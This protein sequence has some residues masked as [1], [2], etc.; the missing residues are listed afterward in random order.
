MEV[1]RYRQIFDHSMDGILLTSPDGAV[2]DANPAACCILR[3]SR[4]QICL[5][6]RAGITVEDDRLRAII[7][8]RGRRGRAC[9]EVLMVRIDGEVFPAEMS[10]SVY[11]DAFGEA[12]TSLIFRDI[13][14]RRRQEEE[15][16]R[17][18]ASLEDVVRERTARLHA[19]HD[20]LQD[21]AYALAHDLH[22]PL[23]A[24]GGL[25]GVIEQ[26]GPPP[27]AA[28]DL[29]RIRA[30]V[31]AMG[32]M[33]DSLQALALIGRSEVKGRWVD[34]AAIVYLCEAAHKAH[35]MRGVRIDA[36]AP[37]MVY[38]DPQLLALVVDE[39]LTNAAK[40]ARQGMPACVRLTADPHEPVA[41]VCGF[42]GFSIT[43]NGIG[44]PSGYE[45]SL[46]R[47]FQR[48]HPHSQFP[49]RGMGL[50]K[51][52]S[53]VH[54]H[55]GEIVAE[56]APGRGAT[57]HVRLWRSGLPREAAVGWPARRESNPRPTA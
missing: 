2:H 7:D 32:E 30:N 13:T 3:G 33:I 23:I 49:G 46:F 31:Q 18:K 47:P 27:P 8:E 53:V 14:Q 41:G 5:K 44:F 40:F 54:L 17:L 25:C 35:G 24:I 11:V 34:L 52:A 39:L 37:L 10:S 20:A 43:D 56:S 1:D 28:G 9:G 51:V 57:F 45:G 38:G 12:Y 22:G 21:F 4:E 16:R 15:I 29:A 55:D 42:R 36:Q 26:K 50:V 6:G 48:L 19:S